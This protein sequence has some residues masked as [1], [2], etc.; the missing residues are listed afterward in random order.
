MEAHRHGIVSGV[1]TLGY[2]VASE[3]L[4]SQQQHLWRKILESFGV[5]QIALFL[6]S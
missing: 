1:F 4:V 5:G 2:I 3:H 6:D